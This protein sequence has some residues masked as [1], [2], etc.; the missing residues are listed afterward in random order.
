MERHAHIPNEAEIMS[1]REVQTSGHVFPQVPNK[2]PDHPCK[3]ILKYNMVH[4]YEEHCPKVM[5]QYADYK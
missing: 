3:V 2:G 5:E 4:I 1:W